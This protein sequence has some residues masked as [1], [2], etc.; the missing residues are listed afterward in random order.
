MSYQGFEDDSAAPRIPS[1]G[2]QEVAAR[3]K[4]N[5]AR[6]QFALAKAH[7]KDP[8]SPER[9]VLARKLR[10]EGQRELRRLG[11]K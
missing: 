9:R 11:L 2:E 4:L 1:R 7:P 3:E 8:H 5:E 6:E 10:R